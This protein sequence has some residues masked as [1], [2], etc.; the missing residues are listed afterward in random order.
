MDKKLKRGGLF[1]QPFLVF[2]WIVN[3]ILPPLI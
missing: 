2:Y 3:L 1:G